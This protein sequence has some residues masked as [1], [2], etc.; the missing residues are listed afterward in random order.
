MATKFLKKW[1][2]PTRSANCAILLLREKKVGLALP[3]LVSLYKK[4]K[5]SLM[6]QLFSSSDPNVRQVAQLELGAERDSV[7]A[8]FKPAMLV[9]DVRAQD[10]TRNRRALGRAAQSLVS[11][12]DALQCH[13]QLCSLPSQGEMARCWIG[14]SPQ[15]RVQVMQNLPQEPM[16][17]ALNSAQDTLP[18]NTNFHW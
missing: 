2:G 9:N 16:K 13:D 17:F 7:R 18:T 3:S 10:T 4:L 11:E 1:A 12:E 8:K 14:K 15:L 5:S 6:A